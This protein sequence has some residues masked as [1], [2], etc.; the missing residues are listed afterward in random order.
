M[1][2]GKYLDL[3]THTLQ[4]D[5]NLTAEQLIELAIANDIGVLSITDHNLV[6]PLEEFQ[7]LQEKYKDK[8]TLIQGSEVSMIYK[9]SKDELKEIHVVVLFKD[10][11]KLRF[12]NGRTMDRVGYVNAI[13]K[14]LFNVG[15]EI[16]DYEHLKECYPETKH[17]GRKHVADWM[18]KH[19]LV[20]SVDDAFDIYIG[21]FGEGRAF[22]DSA[23]YR[24]GYGMME[25]TI[26]EIRQAGGDSVIGIIL[27]HPL[28]YKLDEEELL[29]LIRMFK[30]AAGEIAG[31]EV[32]YA[33]YD[34]EQ[35]AFLKALADGA[36]GE[37]YTFKYS[38][39]S[40]YHGQA[41]SD[42][43]DNQ[44]PVEV[45]EWLNDYL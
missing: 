24:S 18:Y 28:Y 8:I 12:L 2:K 30:D 23:P 45:A 5:G 44:F 42:S 9:T 13:K 37:G 40:D 29:R 22:V 33:R 3:H 26:A 35:R 17:L 27:A 38:A 15:I 14:A 43:L 10:P 16:P 36:A 19:G 20:D 25:D 32:L 34:D 6:M 7:R 31:M 4:S 11:D 21:G 41:D 39:A 1:K